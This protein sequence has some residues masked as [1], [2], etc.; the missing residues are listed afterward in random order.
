M[1]A[2]YSG[3]VLVVDQLLMH[4]A[5]MDLQNNVYISIAHTNQLQ[6]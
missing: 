4:S 1:F 6:I 2:S 5:W 3:H